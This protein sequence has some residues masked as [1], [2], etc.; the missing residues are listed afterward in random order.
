MA[1]STGLPFVP[2][3]ARLGAY[4][5]WLV[6]AL[7][8]VGAMPAGLA[9]VA[10]ALLL[11]TSGVLLGFFLTDARRS[12]TVQGYLAVQTVLILGVYAIDPEAGLG[13]AQLF[14][15]FTAQA[16]LF[17]PLVV[18]AAWV[19]AFAAIIFAGGYYVL[20][21]SNVA[22]ILATASGNV[23][24]AGL[25]GAIRQS[26]RANQ[27]ARAL[28]DEVQRA[29]DELR[30]L[31]DARERLAVAQERERIA[32]EMHDALG[33]RLTVAIVQLEGAQRLIPSDPR[34]AAGMIDDMRGQL[35]E[36]LGEL[37]STVAALRAPGDEPLKR[38]LERLASGFASATGLPVDLRIEL[39]DPPP[40]VDPDLRHALFRVAQEGL[41]NVQR[42]A[43]ASRVRLS[44]GLDGDTL[45]LR[46]EDDGRGLP[47]RP[48]AGERPGGG[49]GYGLDG[50][51]ERVAPWEGRRTVTPRPGGGV[52]LEVTVPSARIGSGAV[53]EVPRG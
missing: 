52:R 15:L 13:V 48:A 23:L 16:V 34:R 51:E 14:F 8:V 45:R 5:V 50:I 19:L 10:A 36:G 12:R 42:H 26:Q 38:S 33:H 32:R 1:T 21:S 3:L 29:H 40:S 18:A 4:A 49:A 47:D 11:A 39:G 43:E 31:S 22:G 17:L 25:A 41:T 53:E 24:F 27:R 6:V 37:R 9:R 20:G 46:V 35:K 2:W 30:T 7:P 44:L 28:L